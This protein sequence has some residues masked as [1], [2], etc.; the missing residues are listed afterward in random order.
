MDELPPYAADILIDQAAARE[1][2]DKQ[3]DVLIQVL[4]HVWTGTTL[5]IVHG[6]WGWRMGIVMSKEE[7]E[8]CPSWLLEKTIKPTS[9]LFADAEEALLVNDPQ[10]KDKRF[11]FKPR[12]KAT[13]LGKFRIQRLVLE[14]EDGNGQQIEFPSADGYG[15]PNNGSDFA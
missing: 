4:R 8:K 9:V 13:D 10:Q 11:G 1:S 6:L 14:H 12:S 7:S 5:A 3:L 2:K 15:D